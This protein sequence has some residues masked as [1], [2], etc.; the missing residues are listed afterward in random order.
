M[1]S[2]RSGPADRYITF[3]LLSL[4]LISAHVWAATAPDVI[5]T[6][7]SLPSP[8]V[9]G[10]EAEIQDFI[11]NQ[12]STATG[13]FEVTY[14]L[15]SDPADS[16][17]DHLIG[18]WSVPG[19]RPGALTHHNSTITWPSSI[20]PGSYYLLRVIDPDGAISGEER[21][22]NVRRSRDLIEVLG[23]PYS[24][25]LGAGT[26]ISQEGTAGEPVPVTV[27]V[28][29]IHETDIESSPVLFYLSP[30]MD[31]DDDLID[32]GSLETGRITGNSEEEISGTVFIPEDTPAGDYFFFTSLIPLEVTLPD[33]SD[34]LFWYN[35]EMFTVISP[36]T[37]SPAPQPQP[38]PPLSPSHPDI[39][40]LDTEIPDDAFI[41]DTFSIP[42]MIQNTGGV[43]ASIV[44]IEYGLSSDSSGTDSRHLDWWTTMNVRAGQVVR[45]NNLAG[46]PSD[47]RPGLYYLTKKVSVTSSPPEQNEANNWWVSNRPVDV[48]YN[49]SS[50]IPELSHV[51]TVWPRGQPG[52]VVQIT[53]TVTNTGRACANDV[54]VAY[55]LSPFPTFD[56]GTAEYLG[57]WTIPV[58]CPGK[59]EKNTI[60][61]T[62]PADL[63]N[64]EYYLYS[65]IDPCFFISGCGAGIPEPD[66]SNNINIGVL[67]IGP[68]PFC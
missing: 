57:V 7:L 50:P 2:R 47:F 26:I 4:L 5:G 13:P 22:N 15:T 54:P 6:R 60:E 31:P 48:R 14:S 10:S 16:D 11:K 12:G 53:D 59:Q 51:R 41:G 38:V 35:E 40:I 32:L 49:P 66:K 44:R 19:L 56:A 46:I 62:I 61:V 25:I 67:Y 33:G 36:A 27:L 17:G 68:C 37:P 23:N 30:T 43:D 42:E 24:G 55:Y 58:V 52:E 34:Q 45:S 65:V 8:L 3:T 63:S 18:T 20:G 28:E 9:I 21:S 29:N 1:H 64:G 39:V